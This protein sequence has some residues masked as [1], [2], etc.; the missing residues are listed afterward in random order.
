MQIEHGT[1]ISGFLQRVEQRVDSAITA[2]RFDVSQRELLLASAAQYRPRTRRNPLGDP[3]AVFYLIARAH[4]DELDEQAVELASFCQFYLLALDLLDDVQDS[5]L[6]GKPHAAVG[7]GMAVND[8]LTLLFL[9]LSALEQCMRLEKSPQRRM[10]YLKIV[11][12]VA[13]TTG[14]GQHRDL[15]GDKGARTPTEVLA[16]QREKTASVTR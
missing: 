5:D 9:G 15:L 13:L 16:M 3:L 11:N 2:G 7:A 12:R 8:A 10:L 6:S 1:G 4:R 14:R